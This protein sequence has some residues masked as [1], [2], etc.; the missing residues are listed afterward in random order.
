MDGENKDAFNNQYILIVE[1]LNQL[2]FSKLIMRELLT[3][4][5]LI[6]DN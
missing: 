3:F 6:Y 2:L 5:D 4:V 1:N